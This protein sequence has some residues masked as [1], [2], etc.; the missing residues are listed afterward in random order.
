[1]QPN[2][3]RRSSPAYL[4]R[5]SPQPVADQAKQEESSSPSSKI[6]SINIYILKRPLLFNPQ[7]NKEIFHY[8]S[9]RT[10]SSQ[11]KISRMA[12][13][14]LKVMGTVLMIT[15]VCSP[16]A[17]AQLSVSYYANTCPSVYDTV[18][19]GVRSAINREARM[20]ASLIR[21]FFH[22]CFVNV[23][24]SILHYIC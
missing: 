22:D 14:L 16:L 3:R 18:R 21:L 15:M 23:S 1:M 2:Q 8:S 17:T 19:A 11:D 10:S 12:S 24:S 6:L 7:P 4:T 5:P 9:N 13:P 20:G